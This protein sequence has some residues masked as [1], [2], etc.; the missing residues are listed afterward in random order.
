M[1]SPPAW[2][3]ADQH[4]LPDE[5]GRLKRD[6]LRDK[7]ADRKAEHIDFRQSSAP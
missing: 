2:A 7:A 6:F 4:Q 5:V 1:P 3:G